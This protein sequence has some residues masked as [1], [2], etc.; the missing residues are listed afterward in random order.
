MGGTHYAIPAAKHVE[1]GVQVKASTASY[2]LF[3]LKGPTT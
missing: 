1:A 3:D 2:G